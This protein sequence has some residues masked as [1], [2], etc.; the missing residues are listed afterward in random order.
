MYPA[1]GKGWTDEWLLLLLLLIFSLVQFS[2]QFS[3]H[4][5]LFTQLYQKVWPVLAQFLPALCAKHTAGGPN[6]DFKGNQSKCVSLLVQICSYVNCCCFQNLKFA[7]QGGTSNIAL[8]PSQFGKTITS[9]GW[10][11]MLCTLRE[12]SHLSVVKT[13][14]PSYNTVIT[15]QIKQER[16]RH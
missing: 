14:F 8:V 11:I 2:F 7:N 4:E 12:L 13:L 6:S 3:N 1:R 5:L 10:A 16:T 9:C 15:K